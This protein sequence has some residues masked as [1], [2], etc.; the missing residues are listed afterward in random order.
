MK[1]RRLKIQNFRAAQDLDIDIQ[2][3]HAIVGANNSGKSTILKAI[4]LLINPSTRKVDEETFWD[5]NIENE[6]RIE[7]IF[8]ELNDHE[9]AELEPYLK[10]DQSFHIARTVKF[11]PDDHS[12][13]F[14]DGKVSISQQFCKLVP[15]HEWLIESEINGKSTS[16]WWS[17]KDELV[18][19]DSSFVDHVGGNKPNVG[20]WKDFA[21]TFIDEYL[22][23]EDFE[24]R[25]FDNPRGYSGVLQGSLPNFILISAVKDISDE[26][27]VTNTSPFGILV[28]QLIEKISDV[29]KGEVDN[30]LVDLQSKLNR[31]GGNTRFES[32]TEIEKSIN[33]VLAN[34]MPVDLEIEFETPTLQ[35]LI[36]SPKLLADD[37]FRNSVE[38]KGHGL[39]RAIIFSI[40]QSY[41]DLISDLE[42]DYTKCTIFGIEE[43]E[44]YMHP[45]A[46]RNIRNVFKEITENNDQIFFTTHSSHLI[47]VTYFDEIIRVEAIYEEQ[48]IKSK[49][50]QL[51]TKELVDDEVARHPHLEG[52]V[53]ENSIRDHYSHAYH[54]SRSEGF[55][56]NKVI[57]VEGATE[58]YALPI[59]AK[60]LEHHLER[61]N[62]GIVDCGGKG[63]IDRLY[64]VFNELGIP[65]YIIFDYDKDNDDKN[66]IDKSVELLS[67]V[68][69]ETEAPD[70]VLI[71]DR[72]TCFPDTLEKNI[73]AGVDGVVDLSK[74]ARKFLGLKSDSGKPLVARYIA[75]KLTEKDDPIVPEIISSILNHAVQVEWVESCLSIAEN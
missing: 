7:A 2:D 47:D 58:Q 45:Q 41:S 27:K 6:I 13:A 49:V 22:S 11:E 12:E 75:R 25:W 35:A 18:V 69:E 52:K 65:C 61:E 54:P 46:Q 10:F 14:E 33:S 4:D 5:K 16:K 63:Q 71:S 60:H 50:W 31:S 15:I 32:I 42:S 73:Y 56:A 68:D 53:T 67:L 43:P 38:N 34:Y 37:G 30:L 57:L 74:E 3:L 70:D 1:L 59:Y 26:A 19:G 17:E 24:T 20:D 28:N 39:Q 8:K 62:I 21:K 64:R 29:Q 36:S 48:S 9:I 51:S 40:L 66:I 23:D 44:I 55:F 72:V